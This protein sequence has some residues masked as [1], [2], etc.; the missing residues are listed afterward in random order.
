MILRHGY[1]AC[2]LSVLV[3]SLASLASCG[4]DDA[5]CVTAVD[6]TMTCTGYASA[7]PYDYGYAGYDTGYYPYTLT[8][9]DDPLGYDVTYGSVLLGGVGRDAGTGRV[10]GGPDAG[11]GSGSPVPELLDKARRAANAI[12]AGIR[13]TL[14]PIKDIVKTPPAMGDDTLTYG[15]MDRGEATYRFTLRRLSDAE[16]RYGWT[17]EARPAG[18][19]ATFVVVA[20]STIQVGA[21]PRRGRGMLGADY[22]AQSSVDPAVRAKGKLFL[23]FASD[24]TTKTLRYAL[25]GYTPD[26]A[27]LDPLDARVT[28]WHELGKA[29]SNRVVT[30]TNLE[31]TETSEPEIVAVKTRW[32][33]GVGARAD[34]I[35]AGGDVPQGSL[36]FVTTCVP[37]TLDREDASTSTKLCT[38]PGADC[39]PEV[40]CAEGLTTADEPQQDPTADDPPAGIPEA[41]DPPS[42]VPSGT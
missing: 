20:G 3:A 39:R 2:S 18:S 11:G 40:S 16:Q 8:V 32:I 30:R 36:L 22:D 33:K 35:A 27:V 13:T 4:S 9:Y 21:T 15:P 41:P 28:G 19:D 17:L 29:S 12:N 38:A 10:D 37:A 6:G 42:T 5:D 7:Y 24:A 26:P 31:E 25:E 14:D 1:S 34:A 23:G